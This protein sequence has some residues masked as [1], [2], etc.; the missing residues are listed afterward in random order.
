MR[1]PCMA[2]NLAQHII[3]RRPTRHIIHCN[4]DPRITGEG[5]D[6]IPVSLLAAAVPDQA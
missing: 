4:D 1:L 5:R 2:L 3:K 6:G